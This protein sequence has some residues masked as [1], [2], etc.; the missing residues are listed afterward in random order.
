ML[1]TG[2]TMAVGAAAAGSPELEVH[3]LG[4][5]EV[6]MGARPAALT[7]GRLRILLAALAMSAGRVVSVDQLAT[8]LWGEEPPADTRR[9]VQ[10]CVTRLRAALGAATVATEPSGYRLPVEPDQVDAVRFVRLLEAAAV[11]ADPVAERKL[12]CEAASL[13][14]GTPFDGIQSAWLETQSP[15]LLERRL[16]ALERR[17]D[18]DLAGERYGEL[19][20]ELD[21]LTADTYGHVLPAR[22][23]EAAFATGRGRDDAWLYQ[24]LYQPPR[25]TAVLAG[26]AG[27]T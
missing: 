4:P 3:L 23:R 11:A 19:V 26:G 2:G 10:V 15:R 7:S 6:R 5:F 22:A 25:S 16:A 18:I 27:G 9:G 1:S 17:I 20:A 13:W 12:L 14:R 21:E 24:W 8:P